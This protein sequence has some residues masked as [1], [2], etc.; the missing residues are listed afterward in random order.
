MVAAI[1]NVQSTVRPAKK[2]TERGNDLWKGLS[3]RYG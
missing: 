1:D 3:S 2:P